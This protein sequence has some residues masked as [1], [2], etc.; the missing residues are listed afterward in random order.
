MTRE[1][2][3]ERV[4]KMLESD[5]EE[6][7]EPSRAA[8][9]RDFAHVAAEYFELDGAPVMQIR[10]GKRGNEVTFTFRAVRVKNFTVLKN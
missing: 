8:A 9:L 2:S 4:L 5:K 3:R 1:T 6:M 7:N 10:R